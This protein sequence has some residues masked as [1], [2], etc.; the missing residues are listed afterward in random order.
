MLMTSLELSCVAGACDTLE[1]RRQT[2]RSLHCPPCHHILLVPTYR[3]HAFRSLMDVSAMLTFLSP[4]T[5]RMAPQ[6]GLQTVSSR[7][8]PIRYHEPKPRRPN[9]VFVSIAQ[10][11]SSPTSDNAA[12]L[13]KVF[14]KHIYDIF[15]KSTIN[16]QLAGWRNGSAQPS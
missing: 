9:K 2:A 8:C 14:A 6:P 4:T 16:Q 10:Q 15:S 3:Q 11:T 13:F 1:T 5:D 7:N 12:C